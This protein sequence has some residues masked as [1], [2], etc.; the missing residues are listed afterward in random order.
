MRNYPQ[1]G[2]TQD[3]SFPCRRIVYSKLQTGLKAKPFGRFASFAALT[4]VCNFE[5]LRR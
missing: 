3:G 1:L 5:S 2:P 4:P